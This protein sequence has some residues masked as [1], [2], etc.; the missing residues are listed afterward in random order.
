MA[1]CSICEK[2]SVT[3]N[4]VSHSQIH[5]KRKFKPNLQKVNGL[6]LCTKCLRTIK[7]Y[8]R[9]EELFQEEQKKLLESALA[10]KEAGVDSEKESD[11]TKAVIEEKPSPAPVKKI[12]KKAQAKKTTKK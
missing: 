3:G 12:T 11:E 8:K 2:R 6:I 1:R 5:T 9:E 10:A 4:T 7:K